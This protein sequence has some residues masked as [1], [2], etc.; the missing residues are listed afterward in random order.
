ML[1]QKKASD[2]IRTYDLLFTRELLY[3]LSY[4]SAFTAAQDFTLFVK[5]RECFN[6]SMN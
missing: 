3:Q 6:P 5:F 4:A 2:G 1:I